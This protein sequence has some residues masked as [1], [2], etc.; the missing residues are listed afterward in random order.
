MMEIA[1]VGLIGNFSARFHKALVEATTLTV[2]IHREKAPVRAVSYINPKGY[3]R[4]RRTI[5]GTLVMTQFA[6]DTLFRFLQMLSVH[7]L[8]KDTAYVKVDQLP[9]FNLTLLFSDEY[10]NASYRRLLGVE[11]VTRSP[12]IHSCPGSFPKPLPAGS[13]GRSS[14]PLAVRLSAGCPAGG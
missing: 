6:V 8:S 11:F 2:S 9:P 5:A 4:G 3:A 7:D 13:A 10:G 12:S 14:P 1:D